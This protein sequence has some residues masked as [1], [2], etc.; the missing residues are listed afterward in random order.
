[1]AFVQIVQLFSLEVRVQAYLQVC[2]AAAHARTGTL[3]RPRPHLHTRTHTEDTTAD[4]PP[5]LGLVNGGFWVC[6]QHSARQRNWNQ[7]INPRGWAPS[8]W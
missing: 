4:L 2:Q 3:A 6:A 1:M 8:W 5:S 7:S